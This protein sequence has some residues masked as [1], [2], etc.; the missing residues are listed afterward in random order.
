MDDAVEVL[1]RGERVWCKIINVDND[2]K[3][4]LSMKHVD[5]G[6]GM[7]LDPNGMKQQLDAQRRKN[8]IPRGR[9]TIKLEAVLDVTCGKC[10]TAGHFTKDCFMPA[11]GKRYKLIPEI[12]EEAPTV[13][14]VKA[15][16]EKKHKSKKIKKKKKK[17]SSHKH[18]SDSESDDSKEDRKIKKRKKHSKE[19]KRKKKRDSSS[20]SDSDSDSDSKPKKKKYSTGDSSERHSKKCKRS[21]SKYSD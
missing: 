8:I 4:G 18:D 11:D 15:P 7:D 1:Q 5:Q 14:D 12:E 19:R 13:P 9:Q 3:I 21:K 17:K 20:L 10:G 2:G 6:D 16:T